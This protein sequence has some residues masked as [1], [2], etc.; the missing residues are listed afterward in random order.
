[1]FDAVGIGVESR[2][3][4]AQLPTPGQANDVEFVRVE[5]AGV[6][7]GEIHVSRVAIEPVGDVLVSPS[8]SN[9]SNFFAPGVSLSADRWQ[10]RI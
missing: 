6:E 10:T 7:K 8:K 4:Q 5:P 9:L 1:M 2:V 3:V